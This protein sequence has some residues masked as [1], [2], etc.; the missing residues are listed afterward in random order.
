MPSPH[1]RR[2]FLRGAAAAATA[3]ALP[4]LAAPRAADA[5][6]PAWARRLGA[7]RRQAKVREVRAYAVPE[8]IFVQVVADD[9]TAGW[10]EAGHDG[11]TLV[12]Q[13]VTRELRPLVVGSDVFD[14]E[15]TW[16]RMYH[17][18]DEMGPGGLVSQAIAG[19]DCALWDLRGRL[20]RQPVWALLGGRFRRDFPLYGSF[21][22]GPARRRLTPAQAA[23]QAARLRAEGFGAIKVRLG[24][25]EENADPPPDQ[26]PAVATVREVRRAIGDDVPLYVDANNGYRPARAIEIGRRLAGEFGVSV[27]EE[28]V[29]A[30]HYPSLGRVADALGAT[31]LAVA[32]GE[33]EYTRWA[34]RDLI[35]QGRPHL[36]NP[37]VSKLAGLTDGKKVAALAETFDLTISVHNA[38]PTLLSA[39]HA[40]YVASCQTATRPQ[41]HPGTERLSEL[42]QFF[43]NRLTP[44][45]GRLA[46]PDGPGLGLD[47][48][49]R[50]VRAAAQT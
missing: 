2:A 36:L 35:L 43:H 26:D 31:G 21:S 48:D 7:E 30:H 23:A 13:V 38:R 29:A 44:R 32:A 11:G 18:A 3:A 39:A 5:E 6:T 50:A 45:D 27:F 34:F 47:V 22:I 15:P 9:G 42:W 4:P 14:A 19:V 10:G 37:D 12:A 17:E 41:E 20:L 24:I 1:D 8:A 46:V 40:H 33:H 25:R 16:A 49:E 28:P